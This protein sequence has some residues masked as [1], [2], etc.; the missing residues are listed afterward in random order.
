MGRVRSIGQDTLVLHSHGQ[1]T[2][3]DLRRGPLVHHGRLT[4]TRLCRRP[5][6]GEPGSRTGIRV[7]C[8]RSLSRLPIQVSGEVTERSP[9]AAVAVLKIAQEAA[10]GQWAV[11]VKERV[12]R[13][14]DFGVNLLGAR[15]RAIGELVLA[16]PPS[17]VA[18]AHGYSPKS[19]SAALTRPPNPSIAQD[20]D[21]GGLRRGRWWLA[22]LGR[23]W[24]PC[25]CPS[26]RRRWRRFA[27]PMAR[28]P[29]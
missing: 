13:L 2:T 21:E 14:R 3:R 25:W 24:H 18:E 20:Q 19:H 26:S 27:I 9:R 28:K 8:E 15:D 11:V 10:A 1:F 12:D 6:I 17:L 29:F 22:R 16:V 7:A 5:A 23:R 4:G